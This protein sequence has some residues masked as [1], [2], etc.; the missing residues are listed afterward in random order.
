[1]VEAVK[2]LKIIYK[3]EPMAYSFISSDEMKGNQ[4]LSIILKDVEDGICIVGY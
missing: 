1:M 3:I 2:K 4:M